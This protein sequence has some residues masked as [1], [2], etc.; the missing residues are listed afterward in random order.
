VIPLPDTYRG[1]YAQDVNAAK[2]YFEEA[3]NIINTG[4]ITGG[5]VKNIIYK[6][7]T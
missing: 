5:D 2:K 1:K 7:L 3:K 6:Y 4:I